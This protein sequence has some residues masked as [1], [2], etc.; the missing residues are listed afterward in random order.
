MFIEYLCH[1]FV[2][3]KYEFP[4]LINKIKANREVSSRE[5][6]ISNQHA[7]LS[8]LMM[9][10]SYADINE[11]A[12]FFSIIIRCW[13]NTGPLDRIFV[14][15]VILKEKISFSHLF[16][17]SFDSVETVEGSNCPSLWIPC[18]HNST[19]RTQLLVPK[20]VQ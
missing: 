12:N 8:E 17:E 3:E 16:Y 18:M 5:R 9:W 4:K 6:Q 10:K 14:G 19:F 15:K 13:L 11:R 2:F 1:W 7:A 20:K